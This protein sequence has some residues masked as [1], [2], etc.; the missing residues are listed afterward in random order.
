MRTLAAFC[1][2]MFPLFFYAQRETKPVISV[3]GSNKVAGAAHDTGR[4]WGADEHFLW[5][6]DKF[7]KGWKVRLGC[8]FVAEE[9]VYPFED[10]EKLAA[11]KSTAQQGIKEAIT[12]LERFLPRCNV[13]V[14]ET[15]PPIIFLEDK[16][17]RQ[18][19][20]HR[21]V[22]VEA[23]HGDLPGILA[24]FRKQG[25][26]VS[27]PYS[28]I[29]PQA[30]PMSF[31]DQI[32]E[33]RVPAMKTTVGNCLATALLDEKLN[34]GICFALVSSP[35]GARQLE[36]QCLSNPVYTQVVIEG[37]QVSLL[38]PVN[39]SHGVLTQEVISVESILYVQ[40]L[41]DTNRPSQREAVK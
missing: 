9:F 4:W 40:S 2:F 6:L 25:I 14:G 26:F 10:C 12:Q 32:R 21:P 37:R 19:L 33:I 27:F 7:G 18:P 29:L 15:K 35:T 30:W 20:L 22:T 13:T 38:D 1:L 5:S 28:I 34:Y 41:S 24:V 8:E 17:L 11:S 23:Y 39:I 36:V 16:R 3:D 31:W